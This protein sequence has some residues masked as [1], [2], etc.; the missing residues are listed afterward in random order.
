MVTCF[1]QSFLVYFL[2][3]PCT[4]VSRRQRPYLFC[5]S[6]YVHSFV[7]SLAHNRC[8]VVTLNIILFNTKEGKA[9]T[10]QPLP[11]SW[12]VSY[13]SLFPPAL[14]H[15]TET[16]LLTISLNPCA[17]SCLQI[18]AC[19]N[20]LARKHS[21]CSSQVVFFTEITF[22]CPPNS[23][24]TQLELPGSFF[25]PTLCWKVCLLTQSLPAPHSY[26]DL[27]VDGTS[28]DH[29]NARLSTKHSQ[30]QLLGERTTDT[31]GPGEKNNWSPC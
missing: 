1:L 21:P 24:K 26:E 12:T 13:T 18:F 4:A 2:P 15:S 31:M 14:K 8:A 23:F 9:S 20:S 29:Q 25:D 30:P 10:I 3:A 17:I 22:F 11:T 19:G 5:S 27:N 28:H 6:L 16:N 7:Q